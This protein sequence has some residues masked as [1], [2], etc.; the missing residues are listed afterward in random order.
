MAQLQRP[1]EGRPG[2]AARSIPRRAGQRFGNSSG[3]PDL[4][5]GAHRAIDGRGVGVGGGSLVERPGGPTFN[6]IRTG[7]PF[8]L[9]KLILLSYVGCIV[10]GRGRPR[11]GVSGDTPTMGVP[12]AQQ[13]PPPGRAALGRDLGEGLPPTPPRSSSL[14]TPRGLRGLLR[15]P[16]RRR[17]RSRRGA[18]GRRRLQG[19]PHGQTR[20]CRPGREEEEGREGQQEED[21]DGRRGVRPGASGAHPRPRRPRSWPP[22]PE[23]AR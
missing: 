2:I 17:G 18:H 3:A 19:H 11:W 5:E 15:R 20:G 10:E 7:V 8:R 23:T 14:S 6:R 1:S 16:N 12:P 13:D 21:G 22:G 4:V 9:D